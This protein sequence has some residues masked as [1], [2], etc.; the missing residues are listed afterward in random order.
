MELTLN[1][2]IMLEGNDLL[3]I[4]GG[5]LTLG[6][7]IAA[8]GLGLMIAGVVTVATGGAAAPAVIAFYVGQWGL[9][10]GIAC[11]CGAKI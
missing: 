9:A 6:L 2:F 10:G 1:K 11:A 3:E 4:D 7:S 5:N 8:M